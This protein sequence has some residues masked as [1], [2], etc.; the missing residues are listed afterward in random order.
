MTS[1]LLLTSITCVSEPK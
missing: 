1:F